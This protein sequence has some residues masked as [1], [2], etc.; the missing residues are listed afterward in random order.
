MTDDL[1]FGSSTV[2]TFRVKTQNVTIVEAKNEEELPLR[3]WQVELILLDQYD[4]E[5]DLDIIQKC[6]FYLH[7]TFANHVRLIKNPPY[8]VQETGWGEFD[9]KIAG[10]FKHHSGS[11]RILHDLL[12]ADDAYIVDY[13]VEIQNCSLE[14]AKMLK[15]FYD[16]DIPENTEIQYPKIKFPWPYVAQLDEDEISDF[17]QMLLENRAVH[18]EISNFDRK[19][20]FYMFMGQV[21]VDEQL[22]LA[23]FVKE[24]VAERRKYEH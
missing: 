13:S 10:T 5:I 12:F 6:K 4:N 16:L 7:P 17:V 14:L 19:E 15:P 11:F 3:R 23:N 21:P 22:R 2:V 24:K 20:P 9:I 18:S 1:P 8:M